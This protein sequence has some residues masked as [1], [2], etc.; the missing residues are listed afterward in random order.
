MRLPRI[1]AAATLLC[2]KA[3]AACGGGDGSAPTGV[4]TP[5]PVA[6]VTITAGTTTLTIGQSA[7]TTVNLRD[8][9]GAVLS[10]RSISYSS[11]AATVASV[12]ANG[13]VIALAAGTATISATS[14]GKVGSLTFTISAPSRLSTDRP[15]EANGSQV[16][17]LY[18][19]PSDGADRLLDVNGTLAN[20][21]GSWQTWFAGQTGGRRFRLDTFGGALDVSFVRLT[22]TDAV[23][24]SYGAF[25]R[26]TIERE[27]TTRGFTVATK[28]YAV[29]YDGG[30]TW[31]CG[32]GA[33]PPGLP[34]RV[35]VMYL[36]GTPAGAP[37]CNTNPFATSASSA[38]GYMEFGMIHEI[39]HTLGFVASNAPRQ[40]LSGH[41][42]EPNDL[43]YAGSAPWALPN[44]V[45]DL[46]RND[47]YGDNVPAG[48]PNLRDSPFLVVQ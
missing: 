46:G 11:S 24:K 29:Y 12:D 30:S 32:G 14:E 42:P 20:T 2:L 9:N 1:R 45:L 4:P 18:V 19:L 41:V 22:R 28:V 10:A 7:Q 34:G 36:Q 8:A 43:M 35:A 13:L 33:W 16:H 6:T 26:D 38:P 39:I 40:T 5:A 27:L 48:V 23:M 17:I 21:I 3:L 25:V 15:D 47:Y 37:G 44:L 31:A